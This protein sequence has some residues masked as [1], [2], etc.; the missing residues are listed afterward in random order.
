MILYEWLF[1]LAMLIVAI[2]LIY[3]VFNNSSW[4]VV[5]LSKLRFRADVVPDNDPKYP[6]QDTVTGT[7]GKDSTP[8][9]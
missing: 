1:L 7:E 9:V 5:L 4:W 2:L 6:M 3:A 8:S